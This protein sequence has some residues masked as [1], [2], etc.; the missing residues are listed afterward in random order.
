MAISQATGAVRIR[1]WSCGLLTA[2]LAVAAHGVGSGT[3]PT[4]ASATQLAVL[5][6]TVGA[7]AAALPRAGEIRVL[8][9]LLAA[10]QLLGHAMLAVGHAHAHSA[11][12]PAWI[13]PTAHV[14]AVGVGAALIATGERWCRAALRGVR[15]VVRAECPPVAATTATAAHRPEQPLRSALLLAASVSHRGPPVSVSC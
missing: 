13:M 5:A 10:G 11:A 15:A 4:G 8:I 14:V 1:G 2:A 6:A 12:L 7:V 3:A 9:G